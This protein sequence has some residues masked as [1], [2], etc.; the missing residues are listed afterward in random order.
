M[1]G[2]IEK[3]IRMMAVTSEY[4]AGWSKLETTVTN[5]NIVTLSWPSWKLKIVSFK[6]DPSEF[7]KASSIEEYAMNLEALDNIYD[8]EEEFVWKTFKNI[9]DKDWN[10]YQKG[11]VVDIVDGFL[12]GDWTPPWKC[13]H[14]MARLSGKYKP[15][16]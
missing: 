8:I 9:N 13:G 2:D 11:K 16:F 5:T 7:V 10:Q 1:L 12:S 4:Q 15:R 6:V 14:C 3:I